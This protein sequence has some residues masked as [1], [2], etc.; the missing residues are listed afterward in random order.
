MRLAQRF[1]CVFFF[2]LMGGNARALS[3]EQSVSCLATPTY[4]PWSAYVPRDVF[5]EVNQD[6]V[7][8]YVHHVIT[9]SQRPT[10]LINN[11]LGFELKLHFYNYDNASAAGLG[12]SFIGE[13]GGYSYC[14]LPGCYRDTGF[15]SAKNSAGEYEEQ[16]SGVGVYPGFA[17]SIQLRPYSYFTRAA[18]GRGTRSLTKA[19]YVPTRKV[20]PVN[21]PSSVFLC[22][23]IASADLWVFKDRV[24]A[25]VCIFWTGSSGTGALL[26]RPFSR[27]SP[28]PF[29]C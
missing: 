21:T 9:F 22:E 14:D 4:V 8:R 17:G 12:P 5:T 26:Q 28:P 10:F 13:P 6:T 16:Y 18:T 11:S 7:S 25:P 19:R 23:D 2:L 29:N 27:T 3:F 24:Y 1:A 15:S 20:V